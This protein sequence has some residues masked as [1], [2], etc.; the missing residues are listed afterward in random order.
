MHNHRGLSRDR[1]T[2]SSPYLTPPSSCPTIIPTTCGS[3]SRFRT[4]TSHVEWA[5]RERTGDGMSG[6]PF[7]P[8]AS[9]SGN[10]DFVRITVVVLKVCSRL[11]ASTS[12]QR[13]SH[14]ILC[15]EDRVARRGLGQHRGAMGMRGY[16]ASGHCQAEDVRQRM[17]LD[18]RYLKMHDRGQR[19]WAKYRIAMAKQHGRGGIATGLTI[20]PIG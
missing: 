17:P 8:S 18:R 3:Y 11:H 9:G 20:H 6:V 14:P 19:S 15:G 4:N 2:S 10:G 12:L 13:K 16:I 1:S 7:H 5:G